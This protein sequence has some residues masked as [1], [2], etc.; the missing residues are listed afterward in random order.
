MSY[1]PTHLLVAG[2]INRRGDAQKHLVTR[3]SLTPGGWKVPK[4][5]SSWFAFYF[6]DCSVIKEKAKKKKKKKKERKKK[7]FKELRL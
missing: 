5:L 6:P 4:A 7:A 2:K 3:W 1:V